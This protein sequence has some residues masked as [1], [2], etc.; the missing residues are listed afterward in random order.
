MKH[1]KRTT[2]MRVHRFLSARALCGFGPIHGGGSG[3][4]LQQAELCQLA[5]QLFRRFEP[6]GLE[7]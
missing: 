3:V 7:A 4:S 6:N 5:L 1:K 2:A